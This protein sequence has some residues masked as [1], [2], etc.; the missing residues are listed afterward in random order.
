MQI[1]INEK[2]YDTDTMSPQ[3]ITLINRI[4][5][6]EASAE[7]FN[8]AKQVYSNDLAKLLEDNQPIGEDTPDAE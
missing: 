8:I 7:A 6:S 2:T 5:G 3:A 4:M 1:T